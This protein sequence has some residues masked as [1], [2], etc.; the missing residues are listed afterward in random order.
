MSHK[1]T[2]QDQTTLVVSSETFMVKRNTAVIHGEIS[3]LLTLAHTAKVPQQV[4]VSFYS[5]VVK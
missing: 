4:F 3:V 2:L 5:W 1:A